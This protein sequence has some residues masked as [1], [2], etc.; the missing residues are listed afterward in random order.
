MTESD[1]RSA[2]GLFVQVVRTAPFDNLLEVTPESDPVIGYDLV[3]EFNACIK[4]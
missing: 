3:D 1:I 2:R 4:I